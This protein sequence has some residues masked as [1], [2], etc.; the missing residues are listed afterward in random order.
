[1]ALTDHLTAV[2]DPFTT[3]YLEKAKDYSKP[4]EAL[5]YINEARRLVNQEITKQDSEIEN[6]KVQN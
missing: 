5:N 3:F 2:T 1:M 6:E 4:E